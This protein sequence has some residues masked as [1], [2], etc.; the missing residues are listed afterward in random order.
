MPTKTWRDYERWVATALGGERVH[1]GDKRDER[2]VRA[3][4]LS[5]EVKHT[6]GIIP[7]A[8]Q[9][10]LDQAKRNAKL[11]TLPFVVAHRP[12]TRRNKAVV[13][14]AF[15]DFIKLLERAGLVREP[16]VVN[17]KKEASDV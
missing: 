14:I 17:A 15:E 12:G 4:G 5:V 11:N 2:D 8:V 10:A 7:A 1:S 9:K 6:L 13:Y 3:P 16:S